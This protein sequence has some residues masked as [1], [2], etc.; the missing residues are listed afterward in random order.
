[1]ENLKDSNKEANNNEN[2]NQEKEIQQKVNPKINKLNIN[3]QHMKLI[4]FFLSNKIYSYKIF[5]ADLNYFN[6]NL[7]ERKE[8]LNAADIRL[9]CKTIILENTAFDKKYESEF[10]QQFYIAI[11]QF[12]TEFHGE[13]LNKNLKLLQN[14]NCSEK[15]SNK[16]FHMRLAKEEQAFEMTGYKYNC[17]TPYLMK[18][19]K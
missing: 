18:C 1:M 5:E 6:M 4:E 19:E 13:K 10:Y 7:E 8:L 14:A 15:L 9:L 16:Y 17:I 3:Y 11:V 12:V 2:K